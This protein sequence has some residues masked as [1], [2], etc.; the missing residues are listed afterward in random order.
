M[1]AIMDV[2]RVP[3]RAWFAYHDALSPLAVSLRCDRTQVWSGET[4]PVDVWVCNDGVKTPEGARVVYEIRQEGRTLAHGASVATIEPCAPRAQG[5]IAVPIPET[6]GRSRIEVAATL[7]GADGSA[8][9]DSTLTL[10]VFPE[11]MPAAGEAWLPARS[12]AA[13]RFLSTV[14]L[15]ISTKPLAQS[16]LVLVT[17]LATY[18]ERAAEI[19]AAVRGGATAVLLN[20]PVGE[21]ELGSAKLQV[22]KAGMGPRHFVS[23]ATGHP[24]VEDLEWSDFKFWHFD[25]LGR[26]API[27]HTVLE[28][29]EW[30]PI[31]LSGDGGWLRPWR[32]TPAAVERCDGQGRWRVCQVE[33]AHCVETNPVAHLF[34]RRLLAAGDNPQGDAERFTAAHKRA[35]VAAGAHV[36]A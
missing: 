27:L 29:E 22:Q 13:E 4:V 7:T 32:Y 8:I 9:H 21:Y 16:E 1:K 19:A 23:P 31:L 28:G 25:S 34:A 36:A 18:E 14:G 24:L 2:D 30:T 35:P 17:D 12:A 11:P 3:K 33:L 10:E 5:R 26:P 15:K 20:L 6:Q